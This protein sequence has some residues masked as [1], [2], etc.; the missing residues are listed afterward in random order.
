[1]IEENQARLE[2][3]EVANVYGFRLRVIRNGWFAIRMEQQL[4]AKTVNGCSHEFS[5]VCV[6]VEAAPGGAPR[7]QA[8]P[9]EHGVTGA[10]HTVW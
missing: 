9:N 2:P 10:V 1:M 8:T 5:G 4:F 6:V 3:M 7:Y